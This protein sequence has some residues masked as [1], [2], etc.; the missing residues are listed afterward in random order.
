MLQ[1][2]SFEFIVKQVC[3]PSR[4]VPCCVFK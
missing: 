2:S 4:W 1:K 3:Q